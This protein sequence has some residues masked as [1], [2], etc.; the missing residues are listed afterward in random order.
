MTLYKGAGC[1]ACGGTGYKG[2]L[3]IYEIME[4]NEGIKDLVIKRAS[5]HEI[6]KVARKNG[7]RTLRGAALK[8]VLDG[9]TTV[10]EMLRVTARD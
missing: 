4:I 1:P 10:D 2:R 3:G 9:E 8:K 7:M 6:K 5:S